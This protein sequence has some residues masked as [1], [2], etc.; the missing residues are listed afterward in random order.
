MITVE[1][2]F[3]DD[4]DMPTIVNEMKQ[5]ARAVPFVREVILAQ[6]GIHVENGLARFR[7]QS[8]GPMERYTRFLF[9]RNVTLQISFYQECLDDI[10]YYQLTVLDTTKADLDPRLATHIADHFFEGEY[11][12]APHTPP[13]VFLMVQREEPANQ[14]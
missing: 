9:Y 3:V 12:V 7:G 1:H 10:I 5:I 2:P 8:L 6:S 13:H 14:N 11:K 4:S